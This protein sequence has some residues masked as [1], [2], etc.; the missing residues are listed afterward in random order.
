MKPI[1]KLSFLSAFFSLVYLLLEQFGF[2]RYLMCYLY[3]TNSYLETYKNIEK[4]GEERMVI[5]LSTT[6]NR[7]PKLIPVLKSLLDQTVRVDMIYVTI[8]GTKEN[9][10]IE[11]KE[12]ENIKK[13][14]NVIEMKNCKHPNVSQ[15]YTAITREGDKNTLIITVGDDIIYGKDFIESMMDTIKEGE[16]KIVYIRE[17]G[18]QIEPIEYI[19]L[20]NGAMFKAGYFSSEF[21]K[22]LE[23][24]NRNWITEYIKSISI[25]IQSLKYSGN[26]SSI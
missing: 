10:D 19:D 26:I 24:K 7:L 18:E 3:S 20:S 8:C 21:I 4:Y 13:I 15:L 11:N 23:H 2:L 5:T 1:V 9:H 14:A 6:Y 16:D 12:I 25:P 17:Q 22:E